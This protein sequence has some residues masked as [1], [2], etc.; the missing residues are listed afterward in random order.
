MVQQKQW[1]AKCFRADKF[2]VKCSVI[3]SKHFAPEDYELSFKEKLLGKMTPRQLKAGVVPSV[4]LPN[5]PMESKSAIKRKSRK[6]ARDSKATL[7]QLL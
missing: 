4:N 7:S 1:I 6:E 5:K 3:C 2:N